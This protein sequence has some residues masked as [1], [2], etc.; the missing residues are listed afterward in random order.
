MDVAL[1]SVGDR[2]EMVFNR[3]S[4]RKN[5]VVTP[6]LRVAQ[7]DQRQCVA[8]CT[9]GRDAPARGSVVAGIQA[10]KRR[11]QRFDELAGGGSQAAALAGADLGERM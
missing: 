1:L 10:R 9:T 2:M 8:C 5:K 6:V 4:L 3:R 11:L 7:H